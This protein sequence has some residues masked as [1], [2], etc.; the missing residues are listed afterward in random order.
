MGAGLSL[1]HSNNRIH[2]ID[3]VWERKRMVLCNGQNS[4]TENFIL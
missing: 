1:E 3:G 2:A 4:T